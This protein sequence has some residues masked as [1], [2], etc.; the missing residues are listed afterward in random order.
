[1]NNGTQFTCTTLILPYHLLIK[2]RQC[3]EVK[4]LVSCNNTI[5]P[6]NLEMIF[7]HL[8]QL[9]CLHF[10]VYIYPFLVGC[11][12]SFSKYPWFFSITTS[13]N[14]LLFLSCVY[15]YHWFTWKLAIVD[16]YLKQL[17]DLKRISSKYCKIQRKWRKENDIINRP[18]DQELIKTSVSPFPQNGFH[19]SKMGIFLK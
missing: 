12:F 17:H 4:E 2:R 13:M 6:L 8:L 3:R 7:E 9:A 16:N 14:L 19:F 5:L 1:M 18:N 11:F 10:S 15:F